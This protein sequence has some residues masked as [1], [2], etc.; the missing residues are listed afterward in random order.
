MLKRLK[1]LYDFSNTWP[2]T[3]I[4]V[5][6]AIFFFAQAF[7]IPSGSMKNTLLEGDFLIVKKFSY[8]IPTPHIPWLEVP[9]LPD[10]NGDGHLFKGKM[11]KR[12]D[13]VVFRFPKN[14]KI[15]FVKRLFAVGGDEVFFEGLNAYLRPHEGDEFLKA[16]YKNVVEINGKLW[17]K[18][19]YQDEHKGINN[20]PLVHELG[21]YPEQVYYYPPTVVEKDRFFMVGDNRDHSDDSRFWG[22]VEYKDIVGTPWFIYLSW[23]NRSFKEATAN[24]NVA[25]ADHRALAR[26]CGQDADLFGEECE[27]KWNAQRYL[28]RWERVGKTINQIE[29]MLRE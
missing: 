14:T 7:V 3:V 9:V 12:G 16:N 23:E 19:P 20:D 17:A 18:N 13:I 2:G 24:K 22:S 21:I 15:H 6:L 26:V 25:L 1:K 29:K 8:G 10:F 4:F 27:K 5:L 11:P 28:I